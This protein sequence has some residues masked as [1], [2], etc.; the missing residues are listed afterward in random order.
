MRALRFMTDVYD[1]IGGVA[2]ANAF[3]QGFQSGPLDPFFKSQV[4]MKIDGSWCL[5]GFAAYAPDMDFAV[6]PAPI[7]ADRLAAGAEPI[8]WAGG[9]ALVIPATARKKEGAFK[10]L[11]FLRSW[12]SVKMLE[13]SKRELAQSQG[14]LYIPGIQANRAHYERLIAEHVEGDAKFPPR[15]KRAIM[16]FRDLLEIGRAHV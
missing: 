2:Q 4:A 14:Q 10:L 3:Q 15:F 9:W 8:T 7:P 11:R 5:D 6:T 1:D 16:G 12:D 13:E